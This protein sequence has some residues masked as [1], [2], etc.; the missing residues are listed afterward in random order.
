ML[1]EGTPVFT[2]LLALAILTGTGT[3]QTPKVDYDMVAR[4]R[5]E[6]LQRSQLANTFSYMTDVLGARLTNSDDME[7]AQRWALDEMHRIGLVN[8]AR[9]PFMNY[10]ASWDM[11]YF[12]LHLLEPDYQ[13]MVG[14]P[15]AHTP[16]TD[17]KLELHVVIADVRTRQDLDRVR[18]QLRGKA[19]LSTPPA[20]INLDRFATGTPRRT[21]E[22]LR[23][24]AHIARR[25]ARRRGSL[26]RE[27]RRVDLAPRRRPTDPADIR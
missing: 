24:H 21:D 26:R 15:I 3:A 19:V 2:Q 13:P 23:R 27:P 22:E 16:G 10:G 7:R 12:S 20:A 17:G 18:G 14:Y 25:H 6:G 1:N 9:E 4:I 5:A 11:E 8:T